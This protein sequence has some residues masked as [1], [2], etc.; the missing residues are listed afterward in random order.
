MT[1]EEVLKEYIYAKYNSVR[2]F[3]IECG[4][5]YSTVAAVLNRGLVNSNIDTVFT[6][7]Q[8]L[9]IRLEPLVK[10]AQIIE[11]EPKT[12]LSRKLEAYQIYIQ[13]E[14]SSGSLTL[15]GVG[16]DDQEIDMFLFGF[17]ALIET[18]RRRRK[19]KKVDE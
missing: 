19:Y 4:L 17:D 8:A 14:A 1:S 3:A 18:I 10:D 7:C 9:G 15:D 12:R 11:L 2:Q 16:L 6:I 5:K 13:I